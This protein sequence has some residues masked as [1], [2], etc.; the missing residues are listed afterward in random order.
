MIFKSCVILFSSLF[1]FISVEPSSYSQKTIES[2][3]LCLE[4]DFFLGSSVEALVTKV[5]E[6]EFRELL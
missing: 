4:L 3:L 6:Q 2:L 5:D 1:L